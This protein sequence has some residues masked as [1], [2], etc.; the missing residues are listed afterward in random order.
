MSQIFTGVVGTAL[1]FSRSV[2]EFHYRV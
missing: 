2:L 1:T